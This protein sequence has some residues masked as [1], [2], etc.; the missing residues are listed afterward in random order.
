MAPKATVIKRCPFCEWTFEA[1]KGDKLHPICS[2]EKPQESDVTEDVIE[3]V[4]DCRNP[5]CVKPITV[6]YYSGKPSFELV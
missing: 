4:Y 1:E 2:T 5:R 3:R 6:C